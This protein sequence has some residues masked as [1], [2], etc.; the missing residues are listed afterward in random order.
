MQRAKFS[1]VFQKNIWYML[2]SRWLKMFL[3]FSQS[4]G[5]YEISDVHCFIVSIAFIL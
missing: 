2:S 5:A 1:K 3:A 4:L